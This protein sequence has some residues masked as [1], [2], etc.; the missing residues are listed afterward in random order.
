MT[1]PPRLLIA[2]DYFYPHWTGIAKAMLNLIQKV[3]SRTKFT[4]L[5]VRYTPELA[6][7]ETIDGARV[8]REPHFVKI[9]RSCYSWRI[10]WRFWRELPNHD[11]ALINSPSSNVLP[12]A[13]LAWLRGVPFIVFHQGDLIL[14]GG[15][16]NR[17]LENVFWYSTYIAGKL[18]KRVSTYTRDYAENSVVLKHFLDKFQPQLMPL[19]IE[20]TTRPPSEKLAPLEKVRSQGK[21]VLGFGG[22]FVEEKG[23]DVLLD[24]IPTIIERHPNVHFAFAGETKIFYENFY[25]RL[26]G[27]VEQLSEHITMLGLLDSVDLVYFYQGIDFILIPSRSDCFNLVQAEACYLGK[28]SLV[29]DIPGARHLVRS[30]GFGVIFPKE[31]PAALADAVTEAL[32][33]RAEIQAQYPKVQAMFSDESVV[34]SFQ[35]LLQGAIDAR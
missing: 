34:E 29:S 12:F 8:I 35:S 17:V 30:T 5:T 25:E 19:V 15:L 9:S 20:K 24:A 23:F 21:I 18:A 3:G 6:A 11:V 13:V 1:S 4:V 33:R 31:N 14:T 2:T 26:K 22:R 27:R 32:S 7:E 28:P 10:L 16:L